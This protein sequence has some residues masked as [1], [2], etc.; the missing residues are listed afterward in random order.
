MFLPRYR[1]TGAEPNMF[2]PRYRKTGAEPN[3][4]LPPK[5]KTGAGPNMFLPRYRMLDKKTQRR[6]CIM[7]T[8]RHQVCDQAAIIH[9]IRTAIKLR[10]YMQTGA[11]PNMFLPPKWKTGAEPNMFLPRYR[12][13]DKMRNIRGGASW[14]LLVTRHAIKLRSALRSYMQTGAVPNTN[15]PHMSMHP[16]PMYATLVKV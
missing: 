9:A 3:M 5:W 6:L 2:L 7:I 14:S 8:A 16:E 13:R 4:F 11:E 15:L 1:K 10:S 12:M